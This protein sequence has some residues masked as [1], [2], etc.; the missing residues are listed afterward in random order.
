M[1]KELERE[2]ERKKVKQSKTD[3]AIGG[4]GKERGTRLLLRALTVYWFDTHGG[5]REGA[6]PS[7]QGRVRG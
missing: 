3:C 4:R 1:T 7:L 6:E 5:R 2:E